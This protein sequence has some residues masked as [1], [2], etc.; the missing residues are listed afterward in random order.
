MGQRLGIRE[1]ALAINDQR[2]LLALDPTIEAPPVRLHPRWLAKDREL[3]REVAVKEIKERFA[4]D[5]ASRSRFE[6]EAEIT[7]ALEHPGVVPVY[8]LGRTPAGVPYYTMRLIRGDRTLDD[9]IRT[10]RL[11]TGKI[12]DG[13][14]H[15][16]M[17]EENA[18]AIEV[19]EDT[20]ASAAT[21][22]RPSPLRR[23]T[24]GRP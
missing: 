15:P 17:L 11:F 2:E 4:G 6:M 23:R 3:D 7:G 5:T 10:V 12:A 20:T 24:A 21:A 22:I 9:A 13:L 16:T 14:I 18:F 8:E 1:Q 19:A